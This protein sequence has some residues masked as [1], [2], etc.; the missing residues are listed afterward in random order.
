M[1]NINLW[2]GKDGQPR[3]GRADATLVDAP[4]AAHAP[5]LLLWAAAE[6]FKATA[7]VVII[8]KCASAGSLA[9]AQ[10]PLSWCAGAEAAG[11]HP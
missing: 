6:A 7:I 8:R 2:L 10:P 3:G 11:L 1:H 9:G 5:K 4:W